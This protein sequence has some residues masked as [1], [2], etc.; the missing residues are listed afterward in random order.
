MDLFHYEEERTEYARL[1]KSLDC[2]ACSTLVIAVIIFL[3]AGSK[4]VGGSEL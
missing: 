1:N 2:I 4:L 3:W